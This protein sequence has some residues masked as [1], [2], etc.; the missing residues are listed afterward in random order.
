MKPFDHVRATR[1]TFAGLEGVVKRIAPPN[2]ELVRALTEHRAKIETLL[3]ERAVKDLAKPHV[4]VSLN[5]FG[6]S[7]PVELGIDEVEVVL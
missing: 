5:I 2:V 4:S 7:V 3:G 6:R 1:G